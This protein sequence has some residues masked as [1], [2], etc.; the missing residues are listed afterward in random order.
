M[1]ARRETRLLVPAALLIACAGLG[2]IIVAE[3]RA[4]PSWRGSDPT[5][6][7]SEPVQALRT[8]AEFSMPPSETFAAIVDRPI[9]SRSR[10][11]LPEG[12]DPELEIGPDLNAVLIG[13]II[14]SEQ[15]IALVVPKGSSR[16]VRLS[17]GDRLQGWILESIESDRVTFTRD[18][19]EAQIELSYDQPPPAR[20]RPRAAPARTAPKKV[21]SAAPSVGNSADSEG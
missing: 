14:S 9:F 20:T 19:V 8:A 5:P 7:G 21:P 2:W 3:L 10:R 11:P 16:F 13:T 6:S 1:I 15:E 18:G 12:E 4:A 17:R